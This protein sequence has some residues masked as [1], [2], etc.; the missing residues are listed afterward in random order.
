M[1]YFFKIIKIIIIVFIFFILLNI[2]LYFYA[3]IT[4][5]ESIKN[6][7]KISFYDINNN[8]TFLG[9]N[10]TKWVKYND[11]SN[12]VINA[13]IS[14]EDKNF[15]K[16]KGFDYLRIVKAM[17]NNISNGKINEGASTISQQYIKNLYLN[18]NKSWKRK[19]SEAFK[20]FELETHYSKKEILEGYLNTINYGSGK[21]GIENASK[22]Y[23]N[24]RSKDLSLAEASLLSGIPKSPSKYN[25]LYNF[26]NAKKRQKVVLKSMVANGYITKE[27][28]IDAYNKKIKIS[29]NDNDNESNVN[30]YKDAVLNEL[31]NIKVIPNSLKKTGGLKIYT[32]LD[33]NAEKILNKSISK[34]TSNDNLEVSSIIVKPNTGQVV[35][36]VGGKNYKKSEYN[37]VTQSKRQVGSTI[38]PFLYYSALENGL[39]PSSTF[40]SEKTSFNI[41]N[42]KIYS[43]HNYNNIYAN[44]NIC[45]S[46]AISYSDNIYAV[47]TNMFL[48]N[49]ELIKTLKKSGIKE[50]ISY[51]PS[52]ALGTK[53]INMLDYS[54]GYISLANN[55]IHNDVY[56]IRKIE[57]KDG[58]V[59][60]KHKSNSKK[61]FNN[62]S[63]FILNEM[64]SKTYDYNYINYTSPTM[65]SVKSKMTKKYAVKSGSTDTD[66]W[67]VGYNS[68]AL[69]MVWVG[70]DNNKILKGSQSRISKN[71]WVDSIEKY[72]KNFNYT[73][74][75]MP[76][77]V[78]AVNVDPIS[79]KISEKN[80]KTTLYYLKGTA[81]TKNEES[82]IFIDTFINKKSN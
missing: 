29:S 81:P 78:I 73:W 10:N 65:I 7:N 37:R 46:A 14:I 1:I 23:F 25:L 18:F 35:A 61:V 21:Y 4:P 26:D 39:T 16:H 80:N 32:N 28:M 31:K 54:N 44:K 5:K 6:A 82:N 57:D 74:Y 62:S 24:K 34:Y 51:S 70:Y 17:L 33:L 66:Y 52:L 71:I 49:D 8:L 75:P 45:M 30:Y 42:K 53:E 58:K 50:N 38:K 40:K 60:Y 36:L 56:L 69:V 41:D 19:I 64:L 67:T 2:G 3:Y 27:Q 12:N 72:L 15:F 79:G 20:T 11:I 76:N 9:S 13:T 77:N 68:K 63:V 43:P 55:G 22:F 59:L 48:G 47:K